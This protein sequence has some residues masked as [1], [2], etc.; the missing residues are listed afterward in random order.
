[1]ANAKA[2]D[3][4]FGVGTIVA[5]PV[6]SGRP[7]LFPKEVIANIYKAIH[8]TGEMATLTDPESGDAVTFTGEKAKA[9]AGG[10]ATRVKKALVNSPDTAYDDPKQLRS[11]TWESDG[12]YYF[13][14]F[15]RGDE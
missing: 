5:P 14:V 7:T 8:E 13:A 9:K 3:N 6:T 10:M 2:K 4:G 1:M 15:E 12:A 11:R